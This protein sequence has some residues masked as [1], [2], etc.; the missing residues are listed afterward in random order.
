MTQNTSARPDLAGLDIEQA[1][2]EDRLSVFLQPIVASGEG[3]G[4]PAYFECL[5]RIL[6]PGSPPI[7]AAQ[8]IPLAEQAGLVHAVDRRVLSITLG[9][10]GQYQNLRLAVNVS[11]MSVA[12][13]GWFTLLKALLAGRTEVA[14]RLIIEIT[15]TAHMGELQDAFQFVGAVKE[16]GCRVALDDFGTGYTSFGHLRDL[17]VDIVKIDGAYVAG[18]TETGR[19]SRFIEAL[20]ALAG[21]RGCSTVAECVENSAQGD[22]LARLGVGYLQGYQYGRPAAAET[23]LAAA[24]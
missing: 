19:D 11:G 12:Y 1:L 9:L 4:K 8:F 17:P 15:E 21:H 14:R 24:A 5:A 3:A 22:S 20:A 6:V 2:A 7:T 13:R 16:L 18:V 10:L 23:V